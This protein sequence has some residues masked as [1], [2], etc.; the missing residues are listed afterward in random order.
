[1]ANDSSH[2][3]F[4][5]SLRG[6]QRLGVASRQVLRDAIRRGELRAYRPTERTVRVLREDLLAWLRAHPVGPG[7]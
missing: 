4:I 7:A 2:L 5:A 1:M 3:P 6:W